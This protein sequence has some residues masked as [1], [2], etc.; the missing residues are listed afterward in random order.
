MWVDCGRPGRSAIGQKRS[1]NHLIFDCYGV[2]MIH[3]A[4]EFVSLRTSADLSKQELATTEQASVETWADVIAR[5][6][7][8][9]TWVAH[10]KT[11]P[12]EILKIL[13]RDRDHSVRASV[14]QKRRLD[15]ELFE[16]LSRDTDEVVRQRIAYNKKTPVE[17]IERLVEDDVPL[18]RDAALEQRRRRQ[19]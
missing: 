19:A 2:L 9:R 1:F 6:P 10:N 17:I 15:Q 5:F 7:E 8:M 13:A 16:A 4:D 12:L 3:S 18:V 11:V 14:A